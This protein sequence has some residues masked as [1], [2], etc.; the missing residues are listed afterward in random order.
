MWVRLIEG[1]GRE[2]PVRMEVS[3]EEG[4]RLIELGVAER[5]D[6]PGTVGRNG[7]RRVVGTVPRVRV[8]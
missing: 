7:I 5:E 2:I 1:L 8:R 6:E 3:E 4:R